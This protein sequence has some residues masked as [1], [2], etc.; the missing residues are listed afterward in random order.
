MGG[1]VQ[2]IRFGLRMLVKHRGVT[3]VAVVTLALGL[4]ANTAIFS[5]MNW[6]MIRPLPVRNAGRLAVIAPK[7]E[8]DDGFTR[9]SYLDFRDLRLQSES[10][11]DVLAYSLNILGLDADGKAEPI[12]ISEVSGNFFQA[13]G[14]RPAAGRLIYGEQAE[15]PGAEPVV[16]LG[17]GFWKKRFN[18]DPRVIGKQV[19]LN[20]QAVTIVGVTPESFHGLCS[21]VDMQAYIPLGVRRLW[22]ENDSLWAN[23]DSR[24]L[25]VPGFLRPGVSLEGAQTSADVVMHRLAMQYPEAEKGISLH[26][27]PEA[28]ARPEPDASEGLVLVA[29]LFSLLAGLV[30]LLACANVANI[31]LVRATAREQEIAVRAALGAKRMRLVRQLLTES[32]LLAA[33]GAAAGL[34]L[35]YGLSSLLS[36]VRMEALNIPLRFDL[37]FDWRVFSYTMGTAALT[38]LMVGLAPAWRA[39]RP[40]LNRVLHQGNR[41]IVAAAG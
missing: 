18:A 29:T 15:K 2:D 19:K 34:A 3:L 41:G 23:R 35:G 21:L 10:L 7:L 38:S 33:L 11:S 27:I 4:G 40:E 8:G 12:V 24:G 39:T 28:L 37:G 25:S 36:S 13:L 16:I 17:Y 31:L 22:S 30:L 26:I 6:L 5:T 32:F 14:L 1:L 9:F 20:G